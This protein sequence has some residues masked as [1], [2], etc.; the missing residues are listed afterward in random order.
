MKTPIMLTLLVTLACSATAYEPP[1]GYLERA[2]KIRDEAREKGLILINTH[3]REDGGADAYIATRQQVSR[4]PE[5]NGKDNPPLEVA[6][7]LALARADV[8]KDHPE[9]EDLLL[10]SFTVHVIYADDFENRWYYT[11]NLQKR[12]PVEGGWTSDNWTVYVMMDGT[13]IKPKL[14]PKE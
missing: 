5:W 14:Y 6:K 9:N 13:V 1:P 11:V 7:A 4:I 3:M 2:R 12:I 10:T 8:L